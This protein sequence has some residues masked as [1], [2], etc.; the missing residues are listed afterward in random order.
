MGEMKHDEQCNDNVESVSDVC[1]FCY[2]QYNLLLVVA[3][4]EFTSSYD[5]PK[6]PNSSRTA[7]DT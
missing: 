5:Y 4:A 1:V 2:D 6:V 3:V 7:D